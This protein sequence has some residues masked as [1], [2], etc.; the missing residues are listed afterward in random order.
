MCHVLAIGISFFFILL[1]ELKTDTGGIF[2][3]IMTKDQFLDEASI[4][5]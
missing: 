3:L 4:P 1:A 5:K 2:A